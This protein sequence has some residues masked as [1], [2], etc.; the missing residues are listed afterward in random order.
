MG[1][2]IFGNL[3][4][5]FVLGSFHQRFYVIIITSIG[6]VACVKLFFMKAPIVQLSKRMIT[7]KL[8]AKSVK[9]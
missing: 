5:A 1:S 8:S 3:L 6:S 7:S 4:A 2:Q 9:P